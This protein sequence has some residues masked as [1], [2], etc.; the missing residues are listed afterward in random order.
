MTF[1]GFKPFVTLHLH[2][3]GGNVFAIRALCER[4]ARIAGKSEHEISAF[5]QAMRSADSYEHS[6]AIVREWFHATI[7]GGPDE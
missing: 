4:M 7:L 1:T 2:G 6:L 3:P 5:L